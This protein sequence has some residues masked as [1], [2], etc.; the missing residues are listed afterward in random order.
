M[1]DPLAGLAAPTGGVFQGAVNLSGNASETINPGV[2]T[3]ISVSGNAKL[4]LNPGIY[5]IAGGGFTVSGKRRLA[6]LAC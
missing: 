2:Y 1:F 5:V 4:I 3:Q 6:A